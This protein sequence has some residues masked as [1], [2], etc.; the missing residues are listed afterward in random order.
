MYRRRRR[1]HE[2]GFSFDSFLDVVTNVVGII[3]RLILV[4]WVGARSYS[5]L[6]LTPP[7]ATPA[8]VAHAD[9]LLPADPL[10]AELAQHRQELDRLQARLL[11]QLRQ[12]VR[13]QDG[14]KATASEQSGLSE[15]RQRLEQ[16]R[17]RTQQAA[18]VS[19]Q[20][21]Q[22]V[23]LSSAELRRRYDNLTKE[24][25]ELEKLPTAKKVLRYQTPVSRPVHTEELFFECNHGRVAF[26]DIG[27]LMVEVGRDLDEHGKALRTQWQL[28]GQAGPVAGFRLRYFVDRERGTGDLLG[29]QAAPNPESSYRAALSRWE[30]EPVQDVRG[31]AA[32]AALATGS[33]FRQIADTID[34][35]QTTVTFWVY[36]DSFTLYRRL[37]DYL[38]ARDVIVAGRPL[39]DGM[40][41]ASS[42]QGTRSRGQ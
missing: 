20:A 11:E 29:D 40:S 21:R 22:A 37:R 32:D 9:E 19:G 13:T 28:T 7:R 15:R 2:I 25:N 34:P 1:K 16:E 10:Q 14:V 8:A 26:I 31:E 6:H 17:V 5:T 4:V 38:Y 3:I 42:R 23:V 18:A 24:I 12:L 35:Q 39:P 36:P 30:I 41:I 33:E 27:T